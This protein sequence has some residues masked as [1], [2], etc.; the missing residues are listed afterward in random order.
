MLVIGS[1]NG[2]AGIAKAYDLLNSGSSPLDAVV[3]GVT[4]VEDDPDEI[5]VGYGGLPNEEGVVELD[6]ALMD[7]RTHRGAGVAALRNVR[8][9]T[10]VARCLMQQTK[11][12]L[13]VG[14]G[15]LKFAK[16][17]GF[18]EEDLLTD[19]ARR[20]WLHWKRHRSNWEDWR[21][22]EEPVDP[23]M[24]AWFRDHFRGTEAHRSHRCIIA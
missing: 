7:G 1:H 13:L 2:L 6:A 16:A 17:N 8:H 19:K 18:R 15:A 22:A 14:E 20:Y 12:V 5:T 11:R 9:P 4:I 21:P 24:L 10:K 23:E 3:E